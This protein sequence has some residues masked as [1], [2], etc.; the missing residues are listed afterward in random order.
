MFAQD[1]ILKNSS[2]NTGDGTEQ[3]YGGLS[4]LDLTLACVTLAS[5]DRGP[6]GRAGSVGPDS[7]VFSLLSQP[8]R[9]A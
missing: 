4:S 6:P 3:D 7:H 2:V 1:S 5:Y 8:H 9:I